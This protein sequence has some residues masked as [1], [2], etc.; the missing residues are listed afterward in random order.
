[1]RV[2][3]LTRTTRTV[4]LT[5]AGKKFLNETSQAIEQILVAQELV[6]S[7]AARPSGVLRL[8]VPE[9]VYPAYLAPVIKRFTEKHPEVEVDVYSDNQMT[10]I[11][12]SGFDAGIRHSEILAKDMVALKLFGPIRFVTVASPSYLNRAGRP[13]HPKELL[14]HNCIRIRFG[15][16]E[17]IYDNWEFEHKGKE[18]EVKVSGSLTLNHSMLIRHA[19]IEGAGVI[20]TV[21]DLIEDDLR[22]KKLEL[23]LE[24]FQAKSP[25][26]YLYYPKKSQ[27]SP[28]LRAFIDH[29]KSELP[30]K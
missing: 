28:K 29:L 1:M 22:S 18:F 12:E 27:V 4:S 10:N 20:Y 11:F 16:G 26:Y 14:S 23:I 21:Y 7:H 6:Q 9:V 17:D 3:L 25:G 13:K 2:T 5:E 15:L 8:N 30:K 19:A 24:D